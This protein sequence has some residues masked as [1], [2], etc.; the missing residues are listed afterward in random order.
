MSWISIS[1]CIQCL[2]KLSKVKEA[3]GPCKSVKYY[4]LFYRK[5]NQCI[6]KLRD[7]SKAKYPLPV[8]NILA[9]SSYVQRVN[10]YGNNTV[11]NW[12]REKQSLL[13]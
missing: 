1:F 9:A 7:Y 5:L 11:R 13:S 12:S 2:K 10:S 3:C 4:Y 6:V 8:A